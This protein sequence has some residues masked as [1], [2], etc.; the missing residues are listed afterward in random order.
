MDHM[1][2]LANNFFYNKTKLIKR[3]VFILSNVITWTILYIWNF[4][5]YC[6]P[7]LINDFFLNQSKYRN[8]HNIFF[9][10][11]KKFT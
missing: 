6:A 7:V 11:F 4:I 10:E 1:N 5:F 9:T 3:S 8:E 2:I